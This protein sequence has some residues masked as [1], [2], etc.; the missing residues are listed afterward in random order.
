MT[1]E[2][3]DILNRVAKAIDELPEECRDAVLTEI[4]EHVAQYKVPQM[5]DSQREEVKRRLALPR[6]HVPEEK[7]REILRRYK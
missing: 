6:R 1:Q 7:V 3:Q 5:T 2:V 4:E